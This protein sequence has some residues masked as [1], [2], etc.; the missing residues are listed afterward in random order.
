M[1]VKQLLLTGRPVLQSGLVDNILSVVEGLI[2][3]G[4]GVVGTVIVAALVLVA[5]IFIGR[6]VD[7]RVYDWAWNNDLDKRAESTPAGA[8]TEHSDTVAT[9]AG[10]LSRYL[11]YLIVVL[12]A[13]RILNISELQTI[14]QNVFQLVPNVIAAI[15]LLVFGVAFART[16]GL[17]IPDLV[18][19]TS[20]ATRFPDTHFGE[21][22]GA[23]EETIGRATGLIAEYYVYFVTLYVV[24]VTLTITP[25][26]QL[27]LEGLLYAPTLV[28][29]LGVVVLGAIVAEHFATQVQ[30]IEAVDELISQPFLTGIGQGLI[31]LFTVVVALSVAG[32]NELVLAVLLLS[33][34]FPLGIGVALALGRGGEG[35]VA[36][37]LGSD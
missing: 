28:A 33:T 30:K 29:G 21:V 23:D 25:A 3:Q 32:V 36:E 10:L 17:F 19:V 7:E 16:L 9:I 4:I 2:Q 24:T 12:S 13:V 31:Y 8:V 18:N 15:V 14:V 37:R 20:V 22:L 6:F 35:F 34:V 27:L 1:V 11:I 5:G 26:A